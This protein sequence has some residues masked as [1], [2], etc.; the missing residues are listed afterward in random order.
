MM[1]SQELSNMGKFLLLYFSNEQVLLA[2]S[3]SSK[4]PEFVDVEGLPVSSNSL[5]LENNGVPVFN[6]DCYIADQKEWREYDE[7]DQCQQEIYKPFHDNIFFKVR[8]IILKYSL[9]V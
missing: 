2:S 9:T 1:L 5:L 8:N 7:T 6:A 4:T 3:M